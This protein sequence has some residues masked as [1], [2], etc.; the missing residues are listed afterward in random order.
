MDYRYTA[1]L[2]RSGHKRLWQRKSGRGEQLEQC[3]WS[4]ISNG[5][6]NG[7]NHT[8]LDS[9][10][11]ANGSTADRG[12]GNSGDRQ[13]DKEV[14][15]RWAGHKWGA[16]LYLT[17]VPTR[18]HLPKCQCVLSKVNKGEQDESF[19]GCQPASQLGH[20]RVD[21]TSPWIKWLWCFCSPMLKKVI[22]TAKCFNLPA[23]DT[24]SSSQ[25]ATITQDQSIT[26]CKTEYMGRGND[27]FY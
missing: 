10:A 12:L 27:L 4:S 15:E 13:Y 19:Y 21:T 18:K 23:T 26:G 5:G 7:L 22:A 20:Q 25:C 3:I 9:W 6:R 14:W 17:F 2:F 24:V 8:H 1:V 11:V 16:V